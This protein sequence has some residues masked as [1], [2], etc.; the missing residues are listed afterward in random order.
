MYKCMVYNFGNTTTLIPLTYQHV[1]NIFQLNVQKFI[2]HILFFQATN[3]QIAAEGDEVGIR[4]NEAFDS[5]VP[6]SCESISV[7]KKPSTYSSVYIIYL[8]EDTFY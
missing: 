5:K 2:I 6:E 3:K 8:F 1:L 7:D 4:K